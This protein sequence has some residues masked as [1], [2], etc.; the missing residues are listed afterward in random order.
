[1]AKLGLIYH[2]NI[3]PKTKNDK[4]TVTHRYRYIYPYNTSHTTLIDLEMYKNNICVISFFQ[5]G[6]GTQKTKYNIR[7]NISAGHCR[8]IMKACIDAYNKLNGDYAFIFSAANDIGEKQ[9][10]NARYS[11]YTL[12]LENYFPNYNNYIRTGSLSLNTLMLYHQ[13]FQ[14]KKEANAFFE[15][16]NEKTNENTTIA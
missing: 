7:T 5:K 3:Y 14:Y 4:F 16:F 15:E 9:E 12:F 11:A 1:M 8:A 13:S 6:I 2:Y 10:Y